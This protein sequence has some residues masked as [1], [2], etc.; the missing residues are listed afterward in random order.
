MGLLPKRMPPEPDVTLTDVSAECEA[1]LAGTLADLLAR[2]GEPPVWS[3]INAVA[4]GNDDRLRALAAGDATDVRAATM[5]TIASAVLAHGGELPTLQREV[6]VPLELAQVGE[7]MTPRR[8]VEL[9]GRALYE[10]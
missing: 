2:H 5:R 8:L 4:H 7:V 6:L 1:L 3:W 10:S 9:V